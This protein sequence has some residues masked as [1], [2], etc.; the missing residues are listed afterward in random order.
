MN[1]L[2]FEPL[3]RVKFETHFLFAITILDSS[4]DYEVNPIIYDLSMF[5]AIYILQ[6]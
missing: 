5:P 1:A 6:K 3:P 4:S 2:Q